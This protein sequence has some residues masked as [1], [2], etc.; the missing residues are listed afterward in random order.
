MRK[1]IELR[2]S[3]EEAHEESNFKNRIAKKLGEKVEEIKSFKLLRRSIDARKKAVKIQMLFEVFLH[4]TPE[5]SEELK[6]EYKVKSGAKEILVI[7]AGP[8]GLYAALGLLEQGFKPILLE[9]GKRVSDR[10]IDLALLNKNHLLNPESNYCFG[11]GGA[12]TFSDGKLYTRSSKRGNVKHILKVFVEHGA[13]PDILIDAHPHLGT[14]KLPGIIKNM[15]KTILDGGGEIHF[16]TRLS[17]FILKNNR[18]RG[19]IDQHGQEYFGEAIILAT[20][21]SARDIYYLL[22]EKGIQL[23]AKDF[24]MGVRIEHPQQLIN[25]IQYHSPVKNPLL[26]TAT[27][28][29]V[30]QA[31]NRGVFSFC[32]CPGGIIVPAAT[33]PNQVVVNGM[34]NADRSSPFANSGIVVSVKQEDLQ[35]YKEYGIFA[36]LEYQKEIE[37]QAFL[38]GG[39]NQTAPA[40]RMLDFVDKK[41]SNTLPKTSYIPG[42]KSAPLHE[43]LPPALSR[44]LA[45]AFQTF[46]KKM[47][48]YYTDEAI[49]LGVESRT[50]SPLRIPR[51]RESMEHIRI[52]NLYPVGEGAGYAGGIVS[53]AIDGYNAS[54]ILS[55]KLK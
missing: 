52:E 22:H 5:E 27:Y 48:G 33:G 18:V 40:Q 7:G 15:R 26:P 38:A 14:N 17:D 41:R 28:S 11:E 44:R 42:I 2:L 35:A 29:L 1:Q 46:G 16:E 12:G 34:S 23:E 55:K 31:Q 53:S 54:Q 25:S 32:M 10:K 19:V 9:R 36:G 8:A 47:H 51:N 49:I 4:E 50:S 13:N 21:H 39:E 24:A 45:E 37:Y 20:G 43:I 30:C 3:P 6:I